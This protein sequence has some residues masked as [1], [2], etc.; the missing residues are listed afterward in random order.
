MASMLFLFITMIVVSSGWAKTCSTIRKLKETSHS[1]YLYLACTGYRFDEYPPHGGEIIAVSVRY[2]NFPL[3]SWYCYRSVLALGSCYV[4]SLSVSTL[5]NIFATS[6]QS[7]H[8]TIKVAI[9]SSK[10][11]HLNIKD[12]CIK[13]TFISVPLYITYRLVSLRTVYCF[14]N[15]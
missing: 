10:N 11:M 12:L 2:N 7:H 13:K 5:W 4:D 8:K 14:S 6:N 9:S 3:V 1:S 15:I